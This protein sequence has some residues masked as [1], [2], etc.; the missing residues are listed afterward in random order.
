MTETVGG[1]LGQ[2]RR[3]VGLLAE[4]FSFLR[5]ERRLWA[6]ASVPVLFAILALGSAGTALWLNLDEV[7]A[8]WLA[9]LPTFEAGR[10]WTWLWIGPAKAFVFLTGW[11]AVVLSFAV[12]LIG[13]LLVANLLSAPF[14]DALSERVEAIARGEAVD[15]D[16][17]LMDLL[18]DTLRSFVAELQRLAFLAFIWL[19]LTLAG[20]V[21][22]G[23]HLITGPLLV[24]TTILFLPLDY[25]GFALDR[26]GV[27]FA[28]RRR[29]LRAQ[30]PTMA[31]FGGVAFASCL[32]PGLNLVVLP[33][34]VTA[35]TLLVLR[36][37]PEA[38]EEVA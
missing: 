24:A 5:R 17:G 9:L 34:L 21:I 33:S 27:S 3:G 14:L 19:A 11:L 12:G 6:L 1:F 20:F 18:G 31:G 15:P 8:A 35:G 25:S 22:P 28:A 26:R 7:H 13:A 4:G 38:G 30:L 32:V 37:A 2:F 10:W 16:E 29:W 36:T 23:A